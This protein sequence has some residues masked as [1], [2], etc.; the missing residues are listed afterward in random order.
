MKLKTLAFSQGFDRG[1][2]GSA[3]ESQDWDSWYAAQCDNIP[4]NAD[5]DDYQAGM[6]L[7]FFSSYEIFEIGDYAEEVDSLRAV[8]GES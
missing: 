5:R 4:T 7:G 6:L 8:W 3:Y 2:Y 1:N